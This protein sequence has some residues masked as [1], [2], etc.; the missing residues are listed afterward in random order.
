ME[1]NVNWLRDRI[2]QIP[3]FTRYYVFACAI[4]S[5]LVTTGYVRV[6]SVFFHT[7]TVFKDHQYWRILTS[8]LYHGPLDF[9]LF[10]NLYYFTSNCSMLENGHFRNRTGLF[11]FFTLFCVAI[12]VLISS[13]LAPTHQFPFLSQSLTS[14]IT[15]YSSKAPENRFGNVLIAGLLPIPA[16][17]TPWV[18]FIVNNLVGTKN[19]DELKGFVAAHLFFYFEQ[20]FTDPFLAGPKVNDIWDRIKSLFSSQDSEAGQLD[21]R[22]Q[23]Q[24][25]DHED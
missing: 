8:F 18:L 15:Y 23:F 20:I 5:L 9:R 16:Q 12:I 14:A 3:K 7:Y 6:E 24:M 13:V 1:R 25:D 4:L 19:W 21:D 22:P 17:Y 10:I 2:E 11:A